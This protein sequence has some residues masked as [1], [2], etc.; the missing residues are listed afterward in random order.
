MKHDD[1]T[2]ETVRKYDEPVGLR[3]AVSDHLDEA[4]GQGINTHIS[5]KVS[6]TQTNADRTEWLVKSEPIHMQQ[7]DVCPACHGQG[8]AEQPVYW[9]GHHS[10]KW[11]PC[12]SCLGRGRI[13]KLVSE[14]LA[15][16][17]EPVGDYCCTPGSGQ[18]CGP[19]SWCCARAGKH[20]HD[21]EFEESDAG[22]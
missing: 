1:D 7:W 20:D 4:E 16:R 18:C 12:E 6:V 19:G 15:D 3:R 13:P 8:G 9:P 21:D 10:Q 22:L 17:D 5:R 14:E 2:L 11:I